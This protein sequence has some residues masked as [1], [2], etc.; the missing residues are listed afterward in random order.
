MHLPKIVLQLFKT[1]IHHV[2]LSLFKHNTD[3]TQAGSEE[4]QDQQF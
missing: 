1:A 3:D 2:L 4:R